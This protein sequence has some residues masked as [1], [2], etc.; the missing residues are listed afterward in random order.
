[1]QPESTICFKKQDP[2]FFDHKNYTSITLCDKQID[3]AVWKALSSCTIEHLNLCKCTIQSWE[4]FRGC[5]MSALCLDDVSGLTSFLKSAS[6]KTIKTIILSNC[7]PEMCTVMFPAV[8]Q[9]HVTHLKIRDVD[10][11]FLSHLT[12]SQHAA[13]PYLK[14]IHLSRTATH[15]TPL[16]ALQLLEKIAKLTLDEFGWL[17]SGL[18][19]ALIH[20]LEKLQHAPWNIDSLDFRSNNLSLDAF[21]R[22]ELFKQCVPSVHSIDVSE[23]NIPLHL[24]ASLTTEPSQEEEEEESVSDE[25]MDVEK[26]EEEEVIEN[27]VEE[28][29][30]ET[31]S[32]VVSFKEGR[33]KRERQEALPRAKS[34]SLEALTQRYLRS[35]EKLKPKTK[36]KRI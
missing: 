7:N 6:G 5:T 13:Y 1:M 8:N 34:M 12:F 16:V 31:S 33:G 3:A 22:I 21:E 20:V 14:T 32:R 25:G 35:V 2:I 15:M 19:D 26:E 17:E 9:L 11:L 10:A 24:S 29:D 18:N 27:V 36:K 4:G 30:G 23:N 28:D